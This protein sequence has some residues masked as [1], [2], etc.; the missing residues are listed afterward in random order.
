MVGLE[1][2]SLTRGGPACRHNEIRRTLFPISIVGKY[3]NRE[4]GGSHGTI[5]NSGMGRLADEKE[6][7]RN[8]E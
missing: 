8:E 7:E 3:T 4:E 5:E 2:D 6:E 1:T